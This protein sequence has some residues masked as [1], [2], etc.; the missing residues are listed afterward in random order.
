MAKKRSG[1]KTQINGALT[2]EN[3]KL[4]GR[5]YL[6]DKGVLWCALSATGAEFTFT[7]K[8]LEVTI[9]G[10]S[11]ASRDD[12]ENQCRLAFYVDG[13]RVIDDMLNEPTR[14]YTV[15]DEEEE[16]T[17]TVR[18]LKLSETAMS[19]MGIAPIEPKEGAVIAPTSH[20]AHRV[21]FIGDSITCG[22]GVDD[23][24]ENHQFRT[25]TEDVTKA[26]AYKTV[27]ALDLDY[28]LFSV[29]GWGI[30]SGYSDDGTIRAEQRIPDYYEKLGF[31]YGDFGEIKPQDID[32]DF[33]RYQPELVVINLGTNDDSY[34]GGDKEREAEYSKRYVSFLKT[35][36]E[37]N[38]HAHI[39]M[40]LGIMGDRLFGGVEAAFEEYRS[41]SGDENISTFRFTPQNGEEDG[42]A[43]N[44]HPTE[45]THDKASAALVEHIKSVM[46]W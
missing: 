20:K 35:V 1:S 12:E 17:R 31:S 6:D 13:E 11:V 14:T 4:L 9:M 30:L 29:S 36:R 39:M 34:C 5:T 23:E 7:G 33:G 15:I 10:D 46:K 28:S 44:W 22:Y 16:V 25:G 2:N 45:R 43:A 3:V 27:Q 18:I 8:K 37:H 19:A 40:C 41:E 21:E 38:P 24:D 42:Y 32:W 26:Y